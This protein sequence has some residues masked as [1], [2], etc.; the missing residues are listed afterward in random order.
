MI[1]NHYPLYIL[2]RSHFSGTV[3]INILV[4]R[5]TE[6]TSP[7]LWKPIAKPMDRFTALNFTAVK[8]VAAVSAATSGSDSVHITAVTQCHVSTTFPQHSTAQHYTTYSSWKSWWK[9]WKSKCIP[10]CYI[11]QLDLYICRAG[12]AWCWKV[13]S[14]KQTQ[15]WCG[16]LHSIGV[17]G[18]NGGAHKPAQPRRQ[19]NTQT[20]I[21]KYL[22]SPSPSPW[23]AQQWVGRG[24]RQ[25]II[26]NRP[27]PEW[28]LVNIF[29]TDRTLSPGGFRPPSLS[30]L[31][32]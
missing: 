22:L 17:S 9:F 28:P 11:D 7:W 20:G 13:E 5:L 30:L 23:A 10:G 26:S 31:L 16:R 29:T 3:C 19:E 18:T 15:I 2:P 8:L 4:T 32:K 27:W 12:L 21:L 25:A 6:G 24:W 14:S 1:T